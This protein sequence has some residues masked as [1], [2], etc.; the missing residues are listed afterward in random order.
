M[1]KDSFI[2][3]EIWYDAKLMMTGRGVDSVMNYEL[4]DMLLALVAD[5]SIGVGDF[6]ERLVRHANRYALAEAMGL[7]NLLGSHD[8]ERIWTRC[9]ADRRKLSLLLAMQF[10]LPGM[11]AVYY[12]DEI[13]MAGDNDPGC[14]G[15]MRWEPEPAD[16]DIWQETAEWIRL[17]KSHPAL[18]G[19][20]LILFA[21][22][23]CK[24]LYDCQKT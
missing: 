8:T 7:Y 12:G 2:I 10:M 14:R 24:R 17:R 1:N 6:H 11:P 5:E 22:E 18:L 23:R 4:R 15:A 3:A 16:S 21:A 13:G 20:D 19:G 9:G